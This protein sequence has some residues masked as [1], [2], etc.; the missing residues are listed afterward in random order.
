MIYINGELINTS[1]SQPFVTANKWLTC[2]LVA[3]GVKEIKNVRGTYIDKYMQSVML[4]E[5][6]INFRLTI[7]DPDVSHAAF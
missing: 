1:P 2:K 4:D 5:G 7:K 3:F 6:Q